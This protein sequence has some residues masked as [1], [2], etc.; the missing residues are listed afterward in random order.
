[1]T[2]LEQELKEIKDTVLEM[3]KLVLNQLEKTGDA[4]LEFDEGLAEEVIHSEKRV[5]ALE[6]TIDKHCENIF[7]LFNPVASDL[8]FVISMLKMN[9]D[10]ERIGDYADGIS[11]YVIDL[12][13]PIDPIYLEKSRIVDMFDIA[14]NMLDMVIVSI[15]S[16][17]T[18]LP[19][20]VFKKDRELNK[21]NRAS[22][23]L[24][25]KMV[26]EDHKNTSSA[27]YLFS[28]IK[29]VERVGDHIKNIA[30]DWIFY[31]DGEIL[32]HK[33]KNKKKG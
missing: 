12:E 25:E 19:R 18:E 6:L 30:E 10:I 4:F 28:T 20:Q 29:K 21:I 2:N 14:Y 27:L 1:M 23:N 7:A 31:L 26:K 15:E 16:E 8:R 22:S 13:E 11:D 24:I 33:K 32:K 3:L 9:S 17:N 5:N